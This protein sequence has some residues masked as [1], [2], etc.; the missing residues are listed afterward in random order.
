MSSLPFAI[1]QVQDAGLIFLSAM[2]SSIVSIIKER[3]TSD[4]ETLSKEIFA[5]TLVWLAIST[6]SLGAALWITGQSYDNNRRGY[7]REGEGER[8]RE[9]E[10]EGGRGRERE[11]E[12]TAP[13]A[14]EH[15][16]AKPRRTY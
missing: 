7:K 8:G 3:S 1:G 12:S 16:P 13:H 9:R 6:F 14:N 4:P 5:T 2:A 11:R 10:R 15:I